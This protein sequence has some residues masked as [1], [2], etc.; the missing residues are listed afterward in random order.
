MI[1]F[2]IR[3]SLAGAILYTAV[4]AGVG[5]T[6][7]KRVALPAPFPLTYGGTTVPAAGVIVG[8]ELADALRGQEL[9]R[10][11]TVGMSIG[12]GVAD[13]VSFGVAVYEGHEEY[14]SAGKIVRA[15][16]RLGD[17]LGGVLKHRTSTA[18]QVARMTNERESLPLQNDRLVSWDIAIPTEAIV[19]DTGKGRTGI[20]FGP[21]LTRVRISDELTPSDGMTHTYFG[22][23]AGAHLQIR[24]LNVFGELTVV[25][26]P[27]GEFRGAATGGRFTV[28]PALGI[29]MLI[30]RV[31][32]WEKR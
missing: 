18:I 11:E 1:R 7:P 5:C 20:Y 30:G 29:T 14:D 22:L 23:L 24:C 3:H 25:H 27:D 6:T 16:V 31:H 9:N 13:R 19:K 28:M 17:V 4:V 10:A 12:A 21:R 2:V 26:V 15:G 8:Y 32:H